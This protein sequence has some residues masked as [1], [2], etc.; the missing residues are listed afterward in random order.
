LITIPDHSK[1]KIEGARD[2]EKSRLEDVDGRAS[3]NSALAKRFS[4]ALEDR[5]RVRE[6]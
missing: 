2:F 4:S 5:A 6:N 3:L 1:A